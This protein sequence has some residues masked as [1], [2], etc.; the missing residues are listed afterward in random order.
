M[1]PA[2]LMLSLRDHLA[3]VRSLHELDCGEGLGEV[4]L[5]FALARKYPNAARDWGWQYVFPSHRLS[6]DPRAFAFGPSGNRRLGIDN[7]AARRI[8]MRLSC[9]A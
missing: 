9:T 2:S 1:V 3:R 7:Y 8:G 6:I 4:H 5:P